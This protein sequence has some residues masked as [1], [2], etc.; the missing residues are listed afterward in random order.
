MKNR[1]PAAEEASS[2]TQAMPSSELP[3]FCGKRPMGTAKRC[4]AIKPNARR[5]YGIVEI[6]RIIGVDRERKLA[7]QID[8]ASAVESGVGI[9]GQRLQLRQAMLPK[10][11]LPAYG[12]Q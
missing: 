1:A 6:F 2:A 7:S 11:M 12:E 9:D 10:T 3:S 5:A 4:G 8:I